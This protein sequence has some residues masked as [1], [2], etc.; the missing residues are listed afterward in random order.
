MGVGSGVS[1]CGCA[2]DWGSPEETVEVATP[3]T[4]TLTG[5]PLLCFLL[6]NYLWHEQ[7]LATLCPSELDKSCVDGI[8]TLVCTYNPSLDSGHDFTTA[9]KLWD[10]A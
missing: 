8:Q 7:G 3:H 2:E 10:L 6:N 5:T 1:P 9:F 4:H